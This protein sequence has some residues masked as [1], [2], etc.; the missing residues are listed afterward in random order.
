[1]PARKK[2]GRVKRKSRQLS[3]G[4]AAEKGTDKSSTGSPPQGTDD[5]V[6]AWP[7]PNLNLSDEDQELLLQYAGLDQTED[8]V[9]ARRLVL[10][11]DH[12]A[13]RTT[14]D[15]LIPT[16]T[17]SHRV[18]TKMRNA[19]GQ[20]CE[21]LHDNPRVMDWHLVDVGE[22][23]LLGTHFGLTVRLLRLKRLADDALS[24]LDADADQRGKVKRKAAMRN[25]CIDELT[26]LFLD[27]NRVAQDESYLR[28][29]K[30]GLSPNSPSAYLVERCT[31]FVSLALN[32]GN[33]AT[34]E[35]AQLANPDS[36]FPQTQDSKL[37]RRIRNLVVT[38]QS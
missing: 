33:L 18:L 21:L 20:L 15:H 23:E 28:D 17:E 24:G 37:V 34:P 38:D 32:V 2:S 36:P 7:P 26:R 10:A 16:S 9:E 14:F 4:E 11:V 31:R 27:L 29:A 35:C 8:P 19:A 1:M 13:F 25:Y 3:S 22:D 6:M 30:L 5:E 12:I